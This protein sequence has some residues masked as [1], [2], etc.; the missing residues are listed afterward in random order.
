MWEL[1]AAEILNYTVGMCIICGSVDIVKML[2]ANT[3]LFAATRLPTLAYF[4]KALY[5]QA[6]EYSFMIYIG[7]F[8]HLSAFCHPLIIIFFIENY[9]T[10]VKR[11]FT[12]T[13]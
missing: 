1:S 6:A 9:R 12:R 8:G 4:L 2:I 11:M 5:W 7:V 3:L 10:H 13:H